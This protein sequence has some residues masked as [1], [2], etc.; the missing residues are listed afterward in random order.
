MLQLFKYTIP[1]ISQV[2][3]SLSLYIS[4]NLTDPHWR[5]I[6]CGTFLL[7]IPYIGIVI[8]IRVLRACVRECAYLYVSENWYMHNTRSKHQVMGIMET[9]SKLDKGVGQKSPRLTSIY[10]VR[11]NKVASQKRSSSFYQQRL[12]EPLALISFPLMLFFLSFALI[13]TFVQQD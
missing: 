12:F 2:A 5:I 3:L 9:L 11:E 13:I 7:T 10:T 8:I 6:V 4:S 1:P